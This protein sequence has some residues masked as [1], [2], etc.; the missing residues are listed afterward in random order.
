VWRT[1][2]DRTL[3]STRVT[4]VLVAGIGLLTAILGWGLPALIGC[5]ESG[6]RPCA[7]DVASARIVGRIETGGC[8]FD[9][10]VLAQRVDLGGSEAERYMVERPV[11]DQGRFA[12]A[13]PGGEYIVAAF[14]E[15]D[16]YFFYAANGAEQGYPATPD[17][18]SV[19]AGDSV[20]VVFRL[21]SLIVEITATAPELRDQRVSLH[22]SQVRE[23]GRFPRDTHAETTVSD[24]MARFT[25]PGLPAGRYTLAFSPGGSHSGDEEIWLPGTHDPA[26]AEVVQVTPGVVATYA[27]QLPE[28]PAVVRGRVF[29]SWQRLGLYSYE[30]SMLAAD[31]AVVLERSVSESNGSFRGE[32][33]IP[34]PIRIACTIAGSTRWIGGD[35]FASATE[36][37]LASGEEIDVGT[38]EES[39]LLVELIEP[40]FPDHSEFSLQ[41]V[42]VD[43]GVLARTLWVSDLWYGQ[44]NLVPFL[45]L[46]PGAYYLRADNSR[47]SM[48]WLSQW[49][50]GATALGEATPI[51]IPGGGTVVPITLTLEAGGSL[52]GR[53]LNDFEGA[54]SRF[55]IYVVEAATRQTVGL[56]YCE[57][58]RGC[59]GDLPNR[60]FLGLG[61]AD[62]EY[63]VGASPH[64]SSTP[65]WD[66][67]AGTIWYPGTAEWD[68]AGIV[69]I[70]DHAAVTGIDIAWP[71]GEP[72]P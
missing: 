38:I 51:T 23:D 68:S 21:G 63:R 58:A 36:F 25:L 11:D 37:G 47:L 2:V 62:G 16:F 67:P 44:T 45:N 31:S 20:E 13:V 4:P 10:S 33:W 55:V 39:G 61:I 22:S 5:S 54:P 48:G 53:V 41:L 69:T 8:P 28:R 30:L 71:P 40:G 7:P 35:D 18:L 65:P 32:V 12:L 34:E 52:S 56:I 46:D 19:A 6:S 60:P 24:G 49:Y 72:G 59:G 3:S 70:A 64:D 29:G 42:R 14:V 15:H 27:A 1:G 57:P 9:A 43:D 17:T 66:A 50:D 26:A